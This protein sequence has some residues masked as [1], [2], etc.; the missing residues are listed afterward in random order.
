MQITSDDLYEFGQWARDHKDDLEPTS[1]WVLIERDN[2]ARPAGKGYSMTDEKAAKIDKAVC[3]L[4]NHNAHL[5]QVFVQHY[6]LGA[7]YKDLAQIHK[8][9][10]STIK[11]KLDYAGG[12]VC[13]AASS[14]SVDKI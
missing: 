6:V 13:G 11:N 3:A 7:S 1:A 2:V 5:G 12:Y 4:T 8:C 14:V 9:S 10:K